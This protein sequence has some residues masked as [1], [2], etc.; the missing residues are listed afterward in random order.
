MRFYHTPYIIVILFRYFVAVGA[1][2][3]NEPERTRLFKELKL[4]WKMKCFVLIPIAIIVLAAFG[5]SEPLN[6][7][8]IGQQVSHLLNIVEYCSIR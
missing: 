2:I 8:L 1:H 3:L 4:A 6:C 5:R 7:T